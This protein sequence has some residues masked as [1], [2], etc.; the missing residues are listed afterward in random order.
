MHGKVLDMVE[1]VNLEKI[2]RNIFRDY[3]QDGLADMLFGLYFLLIGVALPVGSV[4]PFLVLMTVF[5]APLLTGLKKRVTTPR[6]GYVELRQGDPQAMPWFILGSLGLGLVVQVIVLAAAGVLADPGQWY[7]WL[8]VFFG[9]WLGGIFLGLGVRVG[10]ARYY[11]VAALALASGF[12][13]PFLPLTGKLAHIG[14]M[15]AVTGALMLGWGI[16]TFVRFLRKYPL[17]AVESSNAGH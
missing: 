6:A 11:T 1:K 2:E 4:A 5:F 17:Q 15:F 16:V 9:I 13:V 10:L 14:M 8:P 7:R 3:M 12:I